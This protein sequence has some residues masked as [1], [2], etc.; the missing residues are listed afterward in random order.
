MSKSYRRHPDFQDNSR[1]KD[2]RQVR[3]TAVRNKRSELH[4]AAERPQPVDYNEVYSFDF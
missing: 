2:R 1:K 3:E 4:R